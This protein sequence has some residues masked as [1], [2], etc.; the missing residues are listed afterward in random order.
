MAALQRENAQL[1]Q[2][3]A[4]LEAQLASRPAIPEGVPGSSSSSIAKK[5]E[6]SRR[7]RERLAA[8]LNLPEDD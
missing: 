4:A 7:A 8:L 5:V 1:K 2:K 6:E 3:V